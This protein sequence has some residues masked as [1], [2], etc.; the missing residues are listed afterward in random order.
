MNIRIIAVAALLS[1]TLSA[2]A[3][4]APPPPPA[5]ITYGSSGP[6]T[7]TTQDLMVIDKSNAA[8]NA[9]ASP[10]VGWKAQPS[11]PDAIKTWASTKLRAGG[12]GAGH[13]TL[14][15]KRANISKEGL[16]VSHEWD[17]AFTRQQSSK[18]VATAEVSIQADGGNGSAA[19][20]TAN[21]TYYVTLP[22]D[23]TEEERRES[24]IRL[25]DGLINGLDQAASQA[26]NQ[27]MGRFTSSGGG[28]R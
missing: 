24:Y 9:Y 2:C 14:V 21:A 6:I 4:E 13:A 20:A 28:Y 15:I 10:L 1:F 22:E 3:E 23:P 12:G 8:L 11:L 27:H 16:S 19:V 18:Y 17:Q 26:I 5:M 25:V 7:F